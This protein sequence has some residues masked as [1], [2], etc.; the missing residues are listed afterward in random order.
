MRASPCAGASVHS[1]FSFVHSGIPGA[2]STA[3]QASLTG[4]EPCVVA[5]PVRKC[6]HSP[7]ASTAPCAAGGGRA[8]MMEA[9]P[10][11]LPLVIGVT[12]HRDLRDDDLPRLERE[13]EDIITRLRRDRSEERRV[14]KEG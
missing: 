1:A 7:R 9:L 8:A 4:I 3:Q 13:V 11:R 5:M 14:G 12:G 10:D 6:K 2:V